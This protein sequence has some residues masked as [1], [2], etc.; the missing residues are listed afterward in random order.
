M[1]G[2]IMSEAAHSIIGMFSAE[3]LVMDNKA[4]ISDFGSLLRSPKE[5]PHSDPV[6]T[7]INPAD[8]DHVGVGEIVSVPVR[9]WETTN[10]LPFIKDSVGD[11][12]FSQDRISGK[13]EQNQT[14]ADLVDSAMIADPAAVVVPASPDSQTGLGVPAGSIDLEQPEA[15][16]SLAFHQDLMINPGIIE[17]R[18]TTALSADDQAVRPNVKLAS[19]ILSPRENIGLGGGPKIDMA[20][21]FVAPN[22]VDGGSA[23]DKLSPVQTADVLDGKTFRSHQAPRTGEFQLRPLLRESVASSEIL[24]GSDKGLLKLPEQMSEVIDGKSLRSRPAPRTE[25]FQF[26]PQIRENTPSIEIFPSSDKGLLKLQSLQPQLRGEMGEPV[27]PAAK[28]STSN[29]TELPDVRF[30]HP[31]IKSEA[32]TQAPTISPLV[33]KGGQQ[34]DARSELGHFGFRSSGREPLPVAPTSLQKSI[35][36]DGESIEP[37]KFDLPPVAK[38]LETS[39]EQQPIANSSA[40]LAVRATIQKPATFDMSSPQLAQRLATEISDVS[41]TGGTRTFEINPRNLGR[42]EITFTTRGSAEI[43]EIQTDH[44]AAKDI[45]VQHSQVLQDILKSQGR[46]DLT[47]R[48]DVKDNMFSSSKNDGAGLA[49]QENRD[50]REQQSRPS[51]RQK[52]AS[53][54][55]STSENDP[56][57][58]NSRYA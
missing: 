23:N 49:Q 13:V 31:A 54:F 25:E 12:K 46:D 33:M 26:R 9:H 58:D 19:D 21:A 11:R 27:S 29:A 39:I 34:K 18:K 30:I 57:S 37:V 38:S 32:D 53:S 42:M 2:K 43:I 16:L 36:N 35:V 8:I 5:Q 51:Q 4:S 14:T 40:Q 7:E 17:N 1:I 24:P 45:I 10:F 44:R 22:I 48:V 47:F 50:A 52:M 41:V 3:P 28:A 6:G 15:R 56:A 55:D 20:A